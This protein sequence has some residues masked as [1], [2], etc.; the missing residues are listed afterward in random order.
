MNSNILFYEKQKFT[1]WWVW[2]ILILTLG[3]ELY[4]FVRQILFGQ[5]VGTRPV[6]DVFLIFSTLFLISLFVF[7]CRLQ[8]ETTI[9]SEK[10]VMRYRPMIR[11]TFYWDEIEKA[12]VINYGFVGGYGVR[13]GTR[14]GTVYN[15]KGRYGLSLELYDGRRIVIGSQKPEQIEKI[16]QQL[17]KTS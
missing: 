17:H 14:Y 5:P 3:F 15:T 11:K 2:A 7:V 13:I 16:L 4:I 6:P 8:L 12:E 9:D 1:Q 10:I